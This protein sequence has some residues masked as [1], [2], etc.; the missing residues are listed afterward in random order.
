M[1]A[2]SARVAGI[3]VHKKVLVVVVVDGSDTGQDF[4]T[5]SFGATHSGLSELDQFLAGHGV[6][7]VAMESTAEY[8]RPVWMT[9]EGKYEL[10]LTQ[11]RA[12]TAARG[13]KR[14][15]EDARR[16]AHRLLSGDLKA[17]FVPGP[18]QR[19]WRLLSRTRT[20]LSEAVVRLRN[21]I[22]TILE[23]S[24]IKLSSVVSDVLGLSGRRIL[25]ALIDGKTDPAELAAL[26][27]RRLKVDR[28]TLADALTGR[29][30][31]AQ[32]I[33]VRIQ[34]DE[35]EQ[36]EKH[37]KELDEQLAKAQADC[38]DAVERLCE[39][40]GISVLAAQ[41]LIA[42]I[43]PEAKA[44][45]T[46]GHLASW[47]GV[48]PG[49]NESAGVSSTN[50]SPKGN[51][52]L[53]RLLA[54]AAWASVARNGS[55]TQLRY[56]RWVVRT[57]PQK[58]A[59]NVAHYLLRIIWAVLHHRVRYIAPDAATLDQASLL[60][61]IERTARQLRKFGY[62]VTVAGPTLEDGAPA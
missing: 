35:I 28:T 25:R 19:D 45:P 62:S 59:W 23:H 2:S 24:Q 7:R 61:K 50:R 46:S 58:A 39:I 17:S 22:E 36:I 30:T 26:G 34:L 1:T 53:R 44:F 29:M 48:C 5:G 18:E 57:G 4:A 31:A 56:R 15:M 43:G 6:S 40:P 14:D 8:W 41:H 10:L 3:D 16:I 60:R 51:R 52:F 38:Q 20:A 55:E 21:Q 37:M 33:V 12:V 47:V 11:A 42:E 32:Q 49:R 27:D 54:Q 9:L 13:R